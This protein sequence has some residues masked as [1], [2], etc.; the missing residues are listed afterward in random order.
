MIENPLGSYLP[1][2]S[3]LTL[4]NPYLLI[5]TSYKLATESN[6]LT[7]NLLPLVTLTS[8]SHDTPNV[9][10]TISTQNVDSTETKKRLELEEPKS[11]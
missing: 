4:H 5:F 1:S 6:F 9:T 2:Y 7:P 8:F 10:L 11:L 3:P